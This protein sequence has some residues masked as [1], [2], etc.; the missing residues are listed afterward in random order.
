MKYILT[1]EQ[2]READAFT[3]ETLG[4][5]SLELM[6]RAGIALKKEA[7]RLAPTGKILIVC[8]GG[9]NGGDGFV[10]GR[11]LL[12]AGRETDAVFFAEKRTHECEVNLSEFMLNNGRIY[13]EIPDSEYALV[14]DCLFGTGYTYRDDERTA[15]VIRKLNTLKKRG[16]KILSADIPSGVCGNSGIAKG[17][18]VD[19]DVTLCFGEM[20]GG[21]VL[22]DGLDY[23]GEVRRADIGIALPAFDADGNGY[24]RLAEEDEIRQ[25][26]PKR[27]RNTHKGNYG[28]ATVVAGSEKYTGAAYLSTL[29]AVRSGAGYTT[30]M[31]PK[32]L[33]PIFAL[34]IP[35]ALLSITNEGGRYA[36]KEE[37]MAKIPKGAVAYG[38]GMDVSEDV[39]MGA[40]YLLSH[41][42][43]ILVLD[44]DALNSLAEYRFENLSALFQ[45]ATCEVVLTPH[46]REFA[47]LIGVDCSQV[48]EN[49]LSLSQKYAEEWGC[50]V[51]LKGA[52]TIVTDGK[53][54]LIT[55][56]GTA[57][58]A[59]GGSGDVLSGVIAG[60]CASALG[61]FEGALAAAYLCGV[62]AELATADIGEYSLTATDVI[63]Y[64]G[65]A[66][67]ALQG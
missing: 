65:K 14:I 3:I 64:L 51:L 26:L 32:N 1:N 47:R 53:R 57:G 56:R 12:L 44:A 36:F 2:M 8:G 39:A 34:K 24:A 46:P 21:V 41:H 16:A 6:E 11:H 61:G 49:A 52:A 29:A 10:C 58:Q 27:K 28:R 5:P 17:E 13:D 59:K 22:C 50:T 25:L 18:A 15:A 67:L 48:V 40:E 54:T 37:I 7:E 60:L 62:A 55:N 30:L 35:E 4:V 43:G 19:A 31:L 20:K 66:F 23:A 63:S 38:M 33:F 45:N 9:N 42:E